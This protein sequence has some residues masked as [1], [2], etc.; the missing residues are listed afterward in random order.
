MERTKAILIVFIPKI[1]NNPSASCCSINF[2]ILLSHTAHF[3]KN[4]ISH[5]FFSLQLLDCYFCIFSTLQI[6]S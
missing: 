5:D 3:N 4:M 2:D 1:V 6:I